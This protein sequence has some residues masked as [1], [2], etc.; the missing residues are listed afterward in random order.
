MCFVIWT[1]DFKDDEGQLLY[2]ALTRATERLYVT[3]NTDTDLTRKLISD[4]TLYTD[5]FLSSTA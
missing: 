2:V 1:N 4:M 5:K 3:H